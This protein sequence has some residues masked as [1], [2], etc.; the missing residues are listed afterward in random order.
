MR[1]SRGPRF[2]LLSRSSS[3]APPTTKEVAQ[4]VGPARATSIR[5]GSRPP[6]KRC[7]YLQGEKQ[8][9]RHCFWSLAVRVGRLHSKRCKGVR[10]LSKAD[11]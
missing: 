6:R 1:A 4:A 11:R 10:G 2:R 5:Q 9:N 8:A 3:M 7:A